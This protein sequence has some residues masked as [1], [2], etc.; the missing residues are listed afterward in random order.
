MAVPPYAWYEKLQLC[1]H[2]QLIHQKRKRIWMLS[3]AHQRFS[4][5][6]ISVQTPQR[7]PFAIVRYILTVLNIGAN[8]L[9]VAMYTPQNHTFAVCAYGGVLSRRMHSL[10]RS[11]RWLYEYS[12]GYFSTNELIQSLCTSTI[13]RCASILDREVLPATGTLPSAFAQLLW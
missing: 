4:L 12:F 9:D 3:W 8:R 6:L 11:K 2:V 10:K 1:G 13:F 5:C 7:L